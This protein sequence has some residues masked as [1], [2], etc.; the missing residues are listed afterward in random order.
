MNC[1]FDGGDCC[2]SCV[3][4]EKCSECECYTGDTDGAIL[5]RLV[6]NGYCNDVTNNAN[7]DFDGGDCCGSCVN[8]EHCSECACL[9]SANSSNKVSNALVGDGFCHDE[10]NNGNCNYDGGDCCLLRVNSNHCSD[11]LCYHQETCEAGVTHEY[12]GNGI[13]NDETNNAACN[14]DGL[15][16]CKYFKI[17]HSVL[18][19]SLRW[20][21][22]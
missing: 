9:G 17:D 12:L 15:D 1:A 20:I 11:C 22:C 19:N 2:G 18:S 13:C 21:I 14:Y 10:M 5:N 6:G 16:C 4:T 8:M 7:C 3:N